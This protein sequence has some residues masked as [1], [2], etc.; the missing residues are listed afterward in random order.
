MVVS[1][2]GTKENLLASLREQVID[3]IVKPFSAEQLQ[4]AVKNLLAR[5]RSIEVIS[6]SQN[7]IELRVPARF[8]IAASLDNLLLPC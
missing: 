4:S 3:F 5:E 1:A 8:Q 2:F 7:W 6:A